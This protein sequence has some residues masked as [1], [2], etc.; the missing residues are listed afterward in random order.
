M[1]GVIGDVGMDSSNRIDVGY[2]SIGM[3]SSNGIDIGCS[4]IRIDASMGIDEWMG[5]F[6]VEMDE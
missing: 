6:L 1:G 4:S 5:D 3:D 2:S